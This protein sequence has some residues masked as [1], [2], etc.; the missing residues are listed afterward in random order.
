MMNTKLAVL[1]VDQN[2][3]DELAAAGVTKAGI[4]KLDKKSDNGRWWIELKMHPNGSIAS[5]RFIK[6]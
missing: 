6:P 3:S 2:L 5:A 4:K 1:V